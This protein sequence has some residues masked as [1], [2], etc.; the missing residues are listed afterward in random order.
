MRESYKFAIAET[1]WTIFPGFWAMGFGRDI[2]DGSYKVVRMFF[3]PSFWCEILD[4]GG[5]GEWRRVNPPPYKVE[6]L[7]KSTFALMNRLE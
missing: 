6:P 4:V 2:V 3:D 7:R 1:W 5:T